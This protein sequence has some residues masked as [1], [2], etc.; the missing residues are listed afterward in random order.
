MEGLSPLPPDIKHAVAWF[1]DA[2]YK[3]SEDGYSWVP[4]REISS[5]Y[6]ADPNNST[7]PM[8]LRVLGTAFRI[9]YPEAERVTRRVGGGK[10][11]RGWAYMSGP[12]QVYSRDPGEGH[13]TSAYIEAMKRHRGQ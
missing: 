10:Q 5:R 7:T 3:E 4:N 9:A 1:Q 2:G 13:R 12:G 11:R 8:T 6:Q